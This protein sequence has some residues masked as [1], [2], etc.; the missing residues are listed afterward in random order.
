[1]QLETY[2][3]PQILV[4]MHFYLHVQFEQDYTQA[5]NLIRDTWEFTID[6]RVQSRDYS[7]NN[8]KLNFS[9]VKDNPD[10][11]LRNRSLET[12]Y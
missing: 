2:K 9:K 3:A 4:L 6:D 8:M 12:A 10:V 1:M 5:L 7:N 11:L